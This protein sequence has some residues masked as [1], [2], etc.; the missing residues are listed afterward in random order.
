MSAG[1]RGRP[2]VTVVLRPLGSSLPLGLAGLAIA[3]LVTTGL[4]L[5]WVAAAQSHQVGAIILVTVV[6]MQLVAGALA[7]LAR[8]GAT[9]GALGLSSATWATVGVVHLTSPPDS[10]SRALGLALVVGGGL[11]ILSGLT[12]ARAKV[13]PGVALATTG[14]RFVLT[15]IYELTAAGSWQDA[16]GALGIAVTAVAAYAAW[17]LEVED[18]R[19]D[20]VALTMRRGAA[21][22]AVTGP[23][24]EQVDG[25]EHEAGVRR[26]L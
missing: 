12:T 16:A 22:R 15:A 1:D 10:T 21:K 23:F 25:V 24:S 26:Q 7:F 5:G 8:D 6:P 2:P 11:L 9:G 3:S 18:M 17:S 20:D 14:C 19:D 13:L 4:E